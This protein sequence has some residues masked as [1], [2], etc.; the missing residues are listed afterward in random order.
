MKS[1]LL[2][3]ALFSALLLAGCQ[4]GSPVQTESSPTTQL[5]FIRDDEEEVMAK[6]AY[7]LTF[8][9]YDTLTSYLKGSFREKNDSYLFTVNPQKYNPLGGLYLS[10]QYDED[11]DGVYTNPAVEERFLVYDESIGTLSDS[12]KDGTAYSMTFHCLFLPCQKEL[13]FRDLLIEAISQKK[14]KVT[15]RS[16]ESVGGYLY[17]QLT[18]LSK[19][20]YVKSYLQE[21][22]SR[23]G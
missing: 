16:G 23:N 14:I 20:D 19:I 17:I 12:D 10:L 22:L 9:A 7:A 4:T 2:K 6:Q 8:S 5:A 3:T 13:S 18:D 1:L 15:L 11:N 21:N